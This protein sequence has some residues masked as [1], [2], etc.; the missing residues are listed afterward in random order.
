MLQFP[1]FP[2]T[3]SKFWK[4][5]KK[6]KAIKCDGVLMCN[7]LQDAE[8]LNNLILQKVKNLKTVENLYVKDTTIFS[9]II[10]YPEEKGH[11]SLG[12]IFCK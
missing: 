3:L 6:E 2:R 4:S 9:N 12:E 7:N 1:H 10:F 11:M 5:P 8:A